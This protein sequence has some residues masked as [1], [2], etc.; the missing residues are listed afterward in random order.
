[1]DL[2]GFKIDARRNLSLLMW[3]L[4]WSNS[5]NLPKLFARTFITNYGSI[6]Q[7]PHSAVQRKKHVWP[8]YKSRFTKVFHWNFY[9]P[10]KYVL[11]EIWAKTFGI[12]RAHANLL[13]IWH[14][15]IQNEFISYPI[16]L[17][18][19]AA[20]RSAWNNKINIIT[21]LDHILHHSL[22][23]FVHWRCCVPPWL[24]PWPVSAFGDKLIRRN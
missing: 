11:E 18:V 19:C 24:W 21:L 4:N 1:M 3:I 15:V 22:F 7:W 2:K 6:K 10:F 23:K 12:L 14:N 9:G 20:N 13:H 8:T 17:I 5:S 16:V